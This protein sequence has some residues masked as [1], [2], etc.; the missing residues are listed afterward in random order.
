MAGIKT[1]GV[2]TFI[3]KLKRGAGKDMARKMYLAKRKRVEDFA[4]AELTKVWAGHDVQIV[5]K[6]V[7]AGFEVDVI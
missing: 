3:S 2:D 7:Y 1:N 4:R 5:F 6:K